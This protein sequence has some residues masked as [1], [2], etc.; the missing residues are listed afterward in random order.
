MRRN[1]RKS[2]QYRVEVGVHG[3]NSFLGWVLTGQQPK[4][5]QFGIIY[6]RFMASLAMAFFARKNY[7]EDIGIV[8][9]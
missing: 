4:I 2:S 3:V 7:S 1:F 6:M 9:S 5:T 8:F